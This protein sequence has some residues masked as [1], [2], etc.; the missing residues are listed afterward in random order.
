MADITIIQDH[1]LSMQQ[2]RDAAQK[3][4]DQMVL[5]YEMVAEWTGD[6]LSFNCPSVSGAT[7]DCAWLHAE[8]FCGQDRRTGR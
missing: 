8:R 6:V 3:V 7:E 1:S 5:E 2:A 4:V